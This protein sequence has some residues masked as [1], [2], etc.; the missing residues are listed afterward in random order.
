MP[1]S[2]PARLLPEPAIL[3]KYSQPMPDPTPAKPKLS[4]LALGLACGIATVVCWAAGLVAAKHGI[5]NGLGPADIAFHRN[6]WAGLL[7]LPALALR[8]QLHNLAGVGWRRGAV[9]MVL[10]GI[11]FSILSYTGFL[12]VPLGHGGVIQPSTAALGGTL[13]SA[14]VL[15]EVMPT[16][17][18]L[19]AAA[20]VA[21][22][23]LLGW[24]ALATIG[25]HGVLGDLTFAGAGIS[26]AMFALLLRMWRISPLRAVVVVSVVSLAC[27]PFQWAIF[28][29]DRIIAAGWA[30]NL[31]QIAVQGVL[32]GAAAIYLFTRSVVLLGPAR[33]ALFP[34]LVPA[35]TLL[36]GFLALDEV[37]SLVQLAGLAVV[38]VG[39]RLAMKS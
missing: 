29:F 35:T 10:G 23:V 6:V 37:P 7:L 34:A 1:R 4:T 11:P 26:F 31:L 33:A 16:A 13:L 38:A 30:E 32:A 5:A 17:R 25:A 28:G 9:L 36:I 20:I 18:Y 15:R 19:G 3:Q 12:L 8:G 24:E 2:I 39:F 21:G 27:V 14:V 22:L